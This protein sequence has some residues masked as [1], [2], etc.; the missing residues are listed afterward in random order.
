MVA[1]SKRVRGR[2]KRKNAR[3][4]AVRNAVTDTHTSRRRRWLT[5]LSAGPTAATPAEAAAFEVPTAPEP[6]WGVAA[7]AGAGGVLAASGL[8]AM[9]LDPPP[10]KSIPESVSPAS[11][12][13]H[14]MRRRLTIPI[15]NLR[16]RFAV[17]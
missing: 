7:P 11:I 9:I 17:R 1:G 2:K 5:T 6:T 10:T 8:S 4:H 16:S 13:D 3:N 12:G 14:G 15:L